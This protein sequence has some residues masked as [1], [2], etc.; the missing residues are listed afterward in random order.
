MSRKGRYYL[1]IC[2]VTRF[3][4]GICVELDGAGIWCRKK[5]RSASASCGTGSI[6]ASLGAGLLIHTCGGACGTTSFSGSVASS[7]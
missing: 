4:D 1:E 5:G 3:C 2:L 7:G 6:L